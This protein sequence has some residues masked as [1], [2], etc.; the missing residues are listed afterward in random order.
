MPDEPSGHPQVDLVFEGGGVKGI[1]L[2][3]A[4]SMLEEKG[5]VPHN[6]AGSSA[7]AIVA[8]LVAAGYSA[9][10]LHDILTETKFSQFEDAGWEKHI[11]A[12]GAPISILKDH[13]IYR[14]KQFHDWL[15]TLLTKKGITTFGQLKYPNE[16]DPRYRYR[17]QVIVSDVTDR[18]LIILPREADRL[19]L[20][21]DDLEIAQ[22]VRMSMSIPIFFEPVT[23]TGADGRDRV[24]VDGGMLSNF[25]VWI[26]DS[27]G[28]P[29]WPTFGLKL[30]APD[31]KKPPSAGAQEP[32]VSRGA[33]QGLVHY[34]LGLVSTMTDAH[35]KVYLE[36]DTFVRTI[37]ISNLGVR[38]TQFNLDPNLAQQLYQSGRDAAEAFLKTWNFDAYKSEFRA[39]KP[40]SRRDAVAAAMQPPASTP[41]PAP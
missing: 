39:G 12:L 34:L 9:G 35:D 1:A 25:P 23:A 36:R 30:V 4:Y 37:T 16:T 17:L 20:K 8:A 33:R 26:F 24:L 14:G 40:Y 5:Y 19:G 22:A 11:L 3:G 29:E 18:E 38:T 7:G 28:E 13:G 21:P 15:S 41:P 32:S 6:V 10:E 27:D 31:P 2:V